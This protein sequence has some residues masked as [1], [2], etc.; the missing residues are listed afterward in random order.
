MYSR[1]LGFRIFI[2][3]FSLFSSLKF[4]TVAKA[5]LENLCL[6][7]RKNKYVKFSENLNAMSIAKKVEATDQR[8]R[9]YS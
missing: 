4:T 9:L 5:M 7:K 6:D 2:F 3:F 8:G 1:H